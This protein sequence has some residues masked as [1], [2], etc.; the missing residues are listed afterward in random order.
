LLKKTL[1][2][3]TGVFDA[4][5]TTLPVIDPNCANAVKGSKKHKNSNRKNRIENFVRLKLRNKAIANKLCRNQH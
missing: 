2:C 5:V 4:L 3:G 1:A